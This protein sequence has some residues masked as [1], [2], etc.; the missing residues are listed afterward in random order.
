MSLSG[1][2]APLSLIPPGVCPN[3][4]CKLLRRSLFCFPRGVPPRALLIFCVSTPYAFP[5]MMRFWYWRCTSFSKWFKSCSVNA[6]VMRSLNSWTACGLLITSLPSI[7]S[8]KISRSPGLSCRASSS[9]RFRTVGISMPGG[10]GWPGFS[11]IHAR[12]LSIWLDI[13]SKVCSWA[14]LTASSASFSFF[15]AALCAAVTR[16]SA[17]ASIRVIVLSRL[18]S[19]RFV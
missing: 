5:P 4:V 8:R 18:S 9:K 12:P 3:T 7:F 10:S 15:I 11:S 1:V 2:L 13:V 6:F 17:L 19:E 16:R 14:L